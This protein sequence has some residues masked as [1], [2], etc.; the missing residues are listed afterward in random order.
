VSVEAI[1]WAF[2]QDVRTPGAKLVLI[3]LAN[4]ADEAGLCFPGQKYLSKHTSQGVR[5]VRRHLD[6]LEMK[7]WIERRERRRQDGTRTSDL[8]VLNMFP[9][10]RPNLP[11]DEHQ[12]AK[13]DTSSGQI[14]QGQ[15]PNWPDNYT[16]EEP[17]V[18]PRE[19][20]SHREE[21]QKVELGGKSAVGTPFDGGSS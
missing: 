17:S 6:Y 9:S 7:G 19:E 5:T 13:I 3:A 15:R 10:K 18:E 12:A 20:P 14:I 16:S 1:T 4:C 2:K 21:P 8:F 11:V